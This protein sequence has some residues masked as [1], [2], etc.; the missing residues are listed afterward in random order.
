MQSDSTRLREL[1]KGMRQLA[2]GRFRRDGMKVLAEEAR[3]LVVLGFQRSIT[4]DGQ[5]WK[6]SRRRGQVMGTGQILRDTARLQNSIIPRATETGLLVKS[7]VAYAAVHQYGGTIHRAAHTSL[8]R[9]AT[10]SGGRRKR[11]RLYSKRAR[12]VL[13]GVSVSAGEVVIPA[14][15]FLPEG[16]L[17]PIWAPAFRRVMDALLMQRLHQ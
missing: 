15:Q 1:A 11:I 8:Q 13:K 17:G 10:L 7:N 5:P 3:R 6:P 12:S 2:G 16:T 14:R 9:Y 4:P